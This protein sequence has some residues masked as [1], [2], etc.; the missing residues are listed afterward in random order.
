MCVI[1]KKQNKSQK[2]F[3]ILTFEV[4]NMVKVKKTKELPEEVTYNE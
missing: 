3:D 1:F 4:Y 2:V